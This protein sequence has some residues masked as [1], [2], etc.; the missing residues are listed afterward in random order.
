[1]EV[2]QLVSFGAVVR[3]H[4]LEVLQTGE[5]VEAQPLITVQAQARS[6]RNL[7]QSDLLCVQRLV[8]TQLTSFLQAGFQLRLFGP[9]QQEIIVFADSFNGAAQVPKS[10]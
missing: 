10:Q 4:E 7:P 2:C 3:N 8:L 6:Q 1:M 9:I 5:H